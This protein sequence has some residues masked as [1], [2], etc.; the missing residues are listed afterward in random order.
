M[1]AH[2]ELPE[3]LINPGVAVLHVMS[4]NERDLVRLVVEVISE[5]RDK[6]LDDDAAVR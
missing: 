3:S 1:I 2:P 6:V 4:P 5:L